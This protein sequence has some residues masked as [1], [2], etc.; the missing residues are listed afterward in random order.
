MATSGSGLRRQR[1][2]KVRTVDLLAIMHR[3][4]I[5][6][7]LLRLWKIPGCDAFPVEPQISSLQACDH[8]TTTCCN[9]VHCAKPQQVWEDERGFHMLAHGH[10]DENGARSLHYLLTAGS[11]LSKFEVCWRSVGQQATTPFRYIR[12]DPGT[13]GTHLRTQISSPCRTEAM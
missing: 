13:S 8:D 2:G 5:S 4:G 6:T 7:I 9:H 1:V 12:R 11:T 10:F 3:S